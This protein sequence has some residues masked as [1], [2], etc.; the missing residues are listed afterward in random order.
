VRT[1]EI[2]FGSLSPLPASWEWRPLEK[3]IQNPKQDI[4]DGPF[5][6]NLKASEYV[7]EG[8]PIARLQNI[9]RNEFVHKNI[10]FVSTEKARQLG[11]HNFRAGDL[12]ITKLGD[13]LGKACIAPISIAHGIIVADVVRVRIGHDEVDSRYLMYAINSPV[14]A[15]Q[16]E[17]H[18]KGTTR[19]RINLG[20]VRS[21]PIPVAPKEQQ[22]AIVAE[23]E[24]Q[25][26]R[27]D[28]AIASLKRTKAN[29]KRYKA[30]VLKAGVEG[31]LTE[32]WRKQHPDVEP[33][34]KL[35][36]RLLAERRAKWN[37]KG[38]Y[39]EPSATETSNLPSLPEGW[40]WASP[41]QLCSADAYS[42][43]IGPFGS[44]L[45][46]SDYKESGVPLIFVRNIRSLNFGEEGRVYVSITKAAELRAH[47]VSGGDVLVT[48]MGDPPGDACLY[49]ENAPDAIITADCIKLR[50]ARLLPEKRFIVHAI[51]SELVKAQILAITKGVAQLKV[52]LARFS[53]IGIPLPPLTEQ[54]QIAS[55]VERRFSVIDELETAVEA[56]LTRADRLRESVL[57]RA[58]S[59]GLTRFQ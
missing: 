17:K 45:K 38:K 35:L 47:R 12:L 29:L 58:F 48:K 44:N 6:S 11:R 40:S 24:K 8:V 13:P 9:D 54:D 10:R 49:P 36:E 1:T 20:I 32:E 21:L 18:T 14:V 16:F 55:E 33:A 53:G 28:E 27:L 5:G 15:R 59:G 34:S 41:E 30:A 52:S 2:E 23:I 46:V 7:N 42:L 37:G 51:N 25:F 56:N 26:S 19:P 50:L 39:H 31:K 43:A 22:K 4:V 3:L 57:A